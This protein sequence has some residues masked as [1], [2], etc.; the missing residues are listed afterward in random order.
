MRKNPCSE[1]SGHD[2][3]N[4]LG[5]VAAC[6]RGGRKPG[7]NAMNR[8]ARSISKAREERRSHARQRSLRWSA[9]GYCTRFEE[10]RNPGLKCQ[11]KKHHAPKIVPRFCAGKTSAVPKC[12]SGLG[13]REKTRAQLGEF[14]HQIFCIASG[15]GC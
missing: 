10:E 3:G 4:C 5:V 13:A 7:R 12:L 6:R 1:L 14:R 8:A 15:K 2:D 11:S 9:C